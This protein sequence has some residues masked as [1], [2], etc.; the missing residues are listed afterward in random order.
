MLTLCFSRTCP[1]SRFGGVLWRNGQFWQDCH[2]S[3]TGWHISEKGVIGIIVTVYPITNLCPLVAFW[4]SAQPHSFG[5]ECCQVEGSVSHMLSRCSLHEEDWLWDW[6]TVHQL[7][8]LNSEQVLHFWIDNHH[9]PLPPLQI[10]V[11]GGVDKYMAVCRTCYKLPDQQH[12]LGST[13]VRGGE[14]TTGRQLFDFE[15]PVF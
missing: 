10:E 14:I 5:W 13:P 9:V 3:S 2:C 11:I 12:I 4:T 7:H 8:K 6:G 1:V 15:Q